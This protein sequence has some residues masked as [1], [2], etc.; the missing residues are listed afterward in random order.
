MSS[1]KVHFHWPP[2]FSVLTFLTSLT[3]T[4]ALKPLK[5]SSCSNSSRPCRTSPA[6]STHLVAL[7]CSAQSVCMS[8]GMRPTAPSTF[9]RLHLALRTPRFVRRWPWKGS[10]S[11]CLCPSQRHTGWSVDAHLVAR[12]KFSVVEFWHQKVIQC[13]NV[14]FMYY[15]ALH[16]S[17][18][19][20]YES[21][22]LKTNCDPGK[23]PE[24]QVRYRAPWQAW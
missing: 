24:Q 5:P 2:I 16:E 10:I 1:C 21:P 14:L 9:L 20:S 13:I 6:S 18:E 8:C 4:Q 12:Q 3:C 17:Y 22:M 11:S 7:Q 15:N 19:F 23:V